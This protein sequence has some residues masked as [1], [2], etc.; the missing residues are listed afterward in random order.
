MA[1]MTNSGK[2]T[3]MLK[4]VNLS[5]FNVR[6]TKIVKNIGGKRIQPKGRKG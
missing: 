2:R 1:K 5:K 6:P 4:G 3:G